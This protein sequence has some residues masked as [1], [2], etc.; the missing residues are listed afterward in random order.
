LD[1]LNNCSIKQLE[2]I[3]SLTSEKNNFVN[4]TNKLKENLAQNGIDLELTQYKL[5][6]YDKQNNEIEI[7]KTSLL[8]ELNQLKCQ[9]QTVDYT[10]NQCVDLQHKLNE[11]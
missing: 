1:I 6:D 3:N 5:Q 10:E 7:R 4:E 8:T 9:K 2:K 11:K